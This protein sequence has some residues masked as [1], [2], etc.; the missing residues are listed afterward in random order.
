MKKTLLILLLFQTG[1]HL[2]AQTN[3]P[4]RNPLMIAHSNNGSFFSTPE[5]F[6]DSAGVPSAIRW[7]GDT[8]ICVFQWFRQPENSATWDRVAVK[9]SVDNGQH[10]TTPVPI[11]VAG[12][13][14]SYQRPFDPT[15]ALLPDGRLRLYFSSSAGPPPNGLDASVNT[16]SAISTDG[17]HYSFEPGARVDHPDNRVIDPAVIYFNNSWHFAAPIGAPQAGVYHYVS[18]DGLNFSPVPM[19]SS[20]AKHNWT[21]NYLVVSPQELR[22]YGAGMGIIWYNKSTNGGVWSGYQT[23][24]LFG[25]DPTAVKL[26]DNNFLAIYVGQPYSTPA[27]EEVAD[28][29]GFDVTPNKDGTALFIHAR[30]AAAADGVFY[31]HALD[32]RLIKTDSFSNHAEIPLDIAADAVLLV[33]IISGGKVYVQKVI[34]RR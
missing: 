32:G 21:G 26:A 3:P 23:T 14:A 17:V 1:L 2:A 13:P 18:P 11:A 29:T 20:D 27:P 31:L 8:L 6:Q 4:W 7:K 9:F 25:G 28:A 15:L 22:F 12:L 24:N 33:R 34:V 5:I 30:D 16:Y 19:L 10:W